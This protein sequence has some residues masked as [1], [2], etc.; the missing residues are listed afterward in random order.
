MTLGGYSQEPSAD[1]Y[2]S[3]DHLNSGPRSLC[4]EVEEQILTTM[5]ACG[6]PGVPGVCEF[7]EKQNKTK[8]NL[9]NLFLVGRFKGGMKW[10]CIYSTSFRVKSKGEGPRKMAQWLTTLTDLPK[11]QVLIPAP[12]W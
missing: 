10:S 11:D 8:T 4:Q 9:K 2:S 5:A 1:F 7:Q 3:S 6:T 12:T